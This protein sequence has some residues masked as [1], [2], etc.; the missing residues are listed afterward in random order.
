MMNFFNPVGGRCRIELVL[1]QLF[2]SYDPVYIVNQSHHIQGGG[3]GLDMMILIYI[4]FSLS[5]KT[6]PQQHCHSETR[7]RLSKLPFNILSELAYY[8]SLVRRLVAQVTSIASAS[9]LAV[10]LFQAMFRDQFRIQHTNT[11]KSL[12][13]K[14][15]ALPQSENFL[16]V[17]FT[18]PKVSET[19]LQL[20]DLYY[21][22][23]RNFHSLRQKIH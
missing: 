13:I 9:N 19:F 12:V 3:V 5:T 11:P 16:F 1:A 14:K 10:Q 20:R 17:L 21:E 18:A 8:E 4:L 7:R 22:W 6:F 15:Y 23:Y 2:S